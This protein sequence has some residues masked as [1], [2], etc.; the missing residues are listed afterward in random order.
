[1]TRKLYINKL[2]ALVLLTLSI[3]LKLDL[4]IKKGGNQD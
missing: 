1:M 2:E 3:S 4:L